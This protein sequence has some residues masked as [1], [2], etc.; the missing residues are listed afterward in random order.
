MYLYIGLHN[1]AKVILLLF[2]LLQISSFIIIII[3]SLNSKYKK[4]NYITANKNCT[5]K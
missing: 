2:Y 4:D 1:M 3:I 5:V